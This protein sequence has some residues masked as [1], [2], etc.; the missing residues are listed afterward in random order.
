MWL[1]RNILDPLRKLRAVVL[2]LFGV[3]PKHYTLDIHSVTMG[4]RTTEITSGGNK[5]GKS[6]T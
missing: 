3:K 2:K 6:S 4:S 5:H 1:D